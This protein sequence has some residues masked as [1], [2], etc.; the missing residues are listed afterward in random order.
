[1]FFQIIFYDF[2]SRKLIAAIPY[3]VSMPFFTKKE[4]GE[5][6]IREYIKTFYTKGLKSMDGDKNINAFSMVEEILIVLF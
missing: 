5:N 1:M 6:E 4:I 2:K 3:D